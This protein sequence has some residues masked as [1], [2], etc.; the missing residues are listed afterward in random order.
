MINRV[1]IVAILLAGIAGTPILA[2]ASKPHVAPEQSSSA[3]IVRGHEPWTFERLSMGPDPG[4]H[5]GA[6]VTP[7]TS[8]T[9]QPSHDAAGAS[10][11]SGAATNDTSGSSAAKQP[12]DDTNSKQRSETP[13]ASSTGSQTQPGKDR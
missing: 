3:A 7:E 12:P 11:Q 4:G 5:T 1:V 6:T 10:S 8:K 2:L 9:G 13:A